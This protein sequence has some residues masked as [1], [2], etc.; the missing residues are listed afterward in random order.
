MWFKKEHEDIIVNTQVTDHF[1]L[2]ECTCPCCDRV[3]I[4]PRFFEHMGKLE[5][6][7]QELG[8]AIT[9]NSGYRCLKR[10]ADV[11][12]AVNS[13]HTVFATDVRPSWG[14]GFVERLRAMYKMALILEFG[15]IGYYN[16]FLHLDRRLEEARWKG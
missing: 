9:I 10:N 7:R 12:G 5:H 14:E 2:S 3:K 13:Q 15:G 4:I 6:M 16:T 11:G 8:F 1:K